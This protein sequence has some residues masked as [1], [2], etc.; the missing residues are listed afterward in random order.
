[1]AAN[2]RCPQPTPGRIEVAVTRKDPE[3]DEDPAFIPEERISLE[4][5]IAAFTINAAYTNHRDADAGSI[6][7]GKLADLV[8]VEENPLANFKVL[9][10]TGAIRVDESNRAV[11]VGGVRYTIKDGIVFDARELLADV[12]AL[13]QAARDAEG[14]GI[15]VQ[16]GVEAPKSR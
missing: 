7:V 9:Y 12:R 8:V 14:A 3:N 10:G 11:R 16:P 1:M 15:P 6:E 13:V 2:G 4:D 5:A